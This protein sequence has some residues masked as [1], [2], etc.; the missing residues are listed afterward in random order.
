V[1]PPISPSCSVDTLLLL[2]DISSTMFTKVELRSA[3]FN[4]D[5][6]EITIGGVMKGENHQFDN[7]IE[8]F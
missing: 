8:C 3:V 2:S 4:S 6:K 7:R 1:N 5:K